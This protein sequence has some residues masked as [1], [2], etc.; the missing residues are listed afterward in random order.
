LL[1]GLGIRHV[2][3]VTARD[4][5]KRFVTLDAL[6]RKIEVLSRHR[7]EKEASY[8]AELTSDDGEDIKTTRSVSPA[9]WP[10][11]WPRRSAS[12]ASARK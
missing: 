8:H 2:G 12:P 10:M 11:K 4:L 6:R 7:D 9:S 1:F 3:V 5:L